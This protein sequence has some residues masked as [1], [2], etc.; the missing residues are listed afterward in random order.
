M[1][2][3]KTI[4]QSR[5]SRCDFVELHALFT[6]IYIKSVSKPRHT[7]RRVAREQSELRTALVD[8]H[9]GRLNKKVCTAPEG[10]DVCRV[11][12]GGRWE[13]VG[14]NSDSCEEALF[15]EPTRDAS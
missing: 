7:G 1:V 10:Y 5:D 15:A 11:S 9:V 14:D 6:P 3:V 2:R 4:T 13:G 12:S 8:E